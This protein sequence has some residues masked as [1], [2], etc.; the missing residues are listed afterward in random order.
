MDEI[1]VRSAPDNSARDYYTL[2]A[3]TV[4]AV[5]EDQAQGRRLVYEFA[6]RKLRRRLQQQF[7][8]GD[9]AG[10][11]AQMRA[12]ET[13]ID[14]VESQW[15]EKVPLTFAAE[16]PLTYRSLGAD[17]TPAHPAHNGLTIIG[18]E[19]AAAPAPDADALQH[20]SQPSP[21]GGHGQALTA[22][23]PKPYSGA[24]STLLGT[25]QL[26]LA[27]LLAVTIYAAIDGRLTFGLLGRRAP[28]HTVNMNAADGGGRETHA[29]PDGQPRAAK[30]PR[31]G[32]PMPTEYGAYA[33]SNGQLIELDPLP[34]KIPDQRVA[35]SPAISAPSRTHL[36]AGKLAFVVFRR[37][38]V[39]SAPDHIALRVVAQVARALTFDA[40]GKPTST[41]IDDTWVVRSNS[42]Q[43]RVAPL[44]ENPEMIVVRPDPPEAMPPAGRYVL[45]LKGTGYDFTLDGSAADAAHCLE[46]TDALNAP[47][48]TECRNL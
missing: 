48:Y 37:D 2:L 23:P 35:I 31:P 16:P 19:G 15:A 34:M 41:R 42:Y 38:L 12:L 1:A 11:E 5:S 8:E 28:V 9:W 18:R 36:P 47:V 45:V 26:V 39:N 7:E 40:G 32:M 25:A 46:R 10:I 6:R 13:A 27:A 22:L 21:V 17:V 33:L 14:Q 4:A 43:W 44:P 24:R 30:P 29:A 3:R 20:A